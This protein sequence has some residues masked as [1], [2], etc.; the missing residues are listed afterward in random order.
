MNADI[1]KKWV[2]ALRSGRFVQAT[3]ALSPTPGKHCCLG[4]LCELAIEAGI[5]LPV[6]RLGGDGCARY[7]R[8][9]FAL[10]FEV[11]GWAD[12]ENT[13]P[14][15]DIPGEGRLPLSQLNDDLHYAFDRI[16]EVI[17]QQL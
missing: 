17:E 3:R 15:L 10:P 14:R 5:N 11:V 1:K 9:Q 12:L 8:A 6:D 13:D 7:N 4:V 2:D 16:A